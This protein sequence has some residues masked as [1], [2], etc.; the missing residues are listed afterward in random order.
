MDDEPLRVLIEVQMWILL[1]EAVVIRDDVVRRIQ[2][3]RI[4]PGSFKVSTGEVVIG[5]QD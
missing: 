2:V 3:K 1:E 5:V 4:V